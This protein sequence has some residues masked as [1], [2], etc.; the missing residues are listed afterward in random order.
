[1]RDVITSSVVLLFAYHAEQDSV[2]FISVVIRI[3]A[4]FTSH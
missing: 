3:I 1:M 4:Q 2:A